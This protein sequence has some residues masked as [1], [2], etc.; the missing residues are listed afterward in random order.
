MFYV[1]EGSIDDDG[2]DKWGRV[3]RWKLVVILAGETQSE[4]LPLKSMTG[5]GKNSKP[6]VVAT[7]PQARERSTVLPHRINY[8]DATGRKVEKELLKEYPFNPYDVGS[9]SEIRVEIKETGDRDEQ[10][11]RDELSEIHEL[12]TRWE[13]LYEAED[14]DAYI[15]VFG[16]DYFYVS[17]MGT[18]N[19]LKD[20]IRV[21]HWDERDLAIRAFSLWRDIQ[22]E[23]DDTPEIELDGRCRAE[24]RTH[25][26]ITGRV[27]RGV[28]LEGGRESWVAEGEFLFVLEVVNGKWRITRWLDKA[29]N[30]E[31]IDKFG[32]VKT[33]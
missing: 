4:K 24:V 33:Q 1:K 2:F 10:H 11:E 25:Y 15:R 31:G 16:G 30:K 19:N 22:I 18:P 32:N 6:T 9:P 20:D 27:G 26:R 13:T 29:V 3:N 7:L 5:E 8:T 17:D 14:V 21:N 23:L 12:L 28:S